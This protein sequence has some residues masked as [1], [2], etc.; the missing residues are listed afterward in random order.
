MEVIENDRY[1]VKLSIPDDFCM[2][3]EIERYFRLIYS[4]LLLQV[5]KVLL[6]SRLIE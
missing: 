5:S 3:V 6:K 2:I 4:I 1:G